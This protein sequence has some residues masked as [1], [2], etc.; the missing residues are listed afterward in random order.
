MEGPEE[1]ES[2]GQTSGPGATRGYGA[3]DAA[4]ASDV[5]ASVVVVGSW[6]RLEVSGVPM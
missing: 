5:E 1:E 6:T 2:A 3:L 4:V